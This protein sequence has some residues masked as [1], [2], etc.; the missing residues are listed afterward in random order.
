MSNSDL[1]NICLSLIWTIYV[2]ISD[3]DNTCAYFWFGQYMCLFLIRTMY[4]TL[5][6]LGRYQF[7]LQVKLDIFSGRLPCPQDTLVDLAAEAL[8]CKCSYPRGFTPSPNKIKQF[9]LSIMIKIRIF[10][11][12]YTSS[13]N[14]Y[15]ENDDRIPYR[16]ILI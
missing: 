1:D 9:F 3:L 4:M 10:S 5:S 6:D 8:Q 2:F 14:A 16:L 13:K 15:L 7:F 11:N 12:V